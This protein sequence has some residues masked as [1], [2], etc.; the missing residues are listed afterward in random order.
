MKKLL[1][2]IGLGLL[3]TTPVN[4]QD[5]EL[6]KDFEHVFYKTEEVI[7]Q[8]GDAVPVDTIVTDILAPAE[9]VT[10][11]YFD[12]ESQFTT[13]EPNGEFGSPDLSS[14]IIVEDGP[15]LEIIETNT[16]SEEDMPFRY[17]DLS[18]DVA[19][20]YNQS[21]GD[22]TNLYDYGMTTEDLI[23]HRYHT[24]HDLITEHAESFTIYETNAHYILENVT[25]DAQFGA[26]LDDIRSINTGG[27]ESTGY[28]YGILVTI[29]KETGY[30][31]E[32]IILTRAD[33]PEVRIEFVSELYAQYH[34]YN[35]TDSIYDDAQFANAVE[36]IKENSVS[37][38]SHFFEDNPGHSL[39]LKEIFYDID[40][41]AES[42]TTA[43][44]IL[45][46]IETIE[47]YEFMLST[48]YVFRN[49]E[50]F[51]ITSIE[52]QILQGYIAEEDDFLSL[53]AYHIGDNGQK[54]IRY[55]NTEQDVVWLN[56]NLTGGM[57]QDTS[58][59]AVDEVIY[60][61]YQNLLEQLKALEDMTVHETDKYYFL[62]LEG[63]ESLRETFDSLQ[64]TINTGLEA[65]SESY[66]IVSIVDKK[67][68]A[69]TDTLMYREMNT[70]D[71]EQVTFLEVVAGFRKHTTFEDTIDLETLDSQ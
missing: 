12:F 14:G 56:D 30:I 37:V 47:R 18:E 35:E 43:T 44:E 21:L 46:G 33:L 65:G 53:Q 1:G 9:E 57:Y 55:G 52:D 62:S 48:S 6:L 2:F 34:Q 66:G 22:Y 16:M 11:Y 4:A 42:D 70:E 29:D 40:G 23:L 63:D 54:L 45:D 3:L 8:Y 10:S 51:S 7:A 38:L 60:F 17:G 36:Y 15:T 41:I 5:E 13:I 39:Y 28:N 32:S 26:D 64:Y 59:Y 61:R 20:E 68:N 58:Q 49:A 27:Y 31:D 19:V 24:L 25:E 69:L 50:N 71:G 67:K